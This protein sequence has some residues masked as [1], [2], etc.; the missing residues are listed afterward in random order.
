[1]KRYRLSILFLFTALTIFA[2][3]R[4]SSPSGGPTDEIPP[5]LLMSVPDS[6][7]TN[8]SGNTVLLEFDEW[9]KTNN[10]ETNLIITPSIQAGF[11]TKV[12]KRSVLLT[13]QEP[14]ADSTTYTINFG[15]TVQDITNKNVPPNLR[16]SFSTGPFIDSLEISGT[17]LDL[18]TQ[19]PKQG[20]LVSLYALTDSLDITTGSASYFTK[21][22]T[23]GRYNLTNLPSN[24][25]LI[26][27]VVDQ[28]DNLKA[29]TDTESYGFYVDTLRLD[30]SI[31]GIDFTTQK[32]NTQAIRSASNR[33]FGKYYD[34]SFS[35]AIK[36]YSLEHLDSNIPLPPYLLNTPNSIRLYNAREVYGDTTQLIVTVTDSLETQITD[37]LSYYF[38]D[39]KIKSDPFTFQIFPNAND[40]QPE[41]PFSL[42]FSKPV[43]TFLKDSLFYQIDSITTAHPQDTSFIW[44]TNKTKLSWDLLLPDHIAPGESLE[45]IIKPGTFISVEGD[46]SLLK[47]KPIKYSTLNDT[48]LISGSVTTNASNYIIQLVNP[49]TMEVIDQLNNQPSYSFIFLSTDS[50]FVRVIDDANANGIWDTGNILTRTPPEKVTYYY[51]TFKKTKLITIRKNWELSDI[52]ISMTVDN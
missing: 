51:D 17:V 29:D 41:V 16:L 30:S 28:N 47:T 44:N 5:T 48:G 2:C 11:K 38:I 19:D 9:V 39:S 27:A 4:I 31:S 26:Y 8:Y 1:M 40:L 37:T 6:A 12:N 46:S 23:A 3:A 15:N 20:T 7:Q 13:F 33:P 18:Y 35:R 25:Y 50:Y 34:I 43:D 24:D 22:D 52:N 45:L 21:T 14:F 42:E 32:L 49:K 10:I 36:D